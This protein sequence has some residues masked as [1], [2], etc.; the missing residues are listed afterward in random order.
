MTEVSP[1]DASLLSK[2]VELGNRNRNT[3]GLMPKGAFREFARRG[4]LLVAHID[5]EFVGYALYEV[6]RRRVRLT[7]LCVDDNSRSNGVARE[8]VDTLS[9]KHHDLAGI[10]VTCR[11]DFPADGLWP[12]LGFHARHARPGRGKDPTT[13]IHWWRDHGLPDLFTTSAN[14]EV[15]VVAIDHNVF[16]DLV[17]EPDR[18]DAEESRALEADWLVGR[19]RLAV[20]RETPNEIRKNLDAIERLR[21][22]SK[23]E[24]FTQLQYTPVERDRAKAAW[25]GAV[26]SPRRKDAEDCRHLISAAAGGVRIFVTRD[27]DLI[28]RYRTH[29]ADALGLR[30]LRPSELIVQLDEVADAA[31]YRPVDLEGTELSVGVYGNE[32][33]GELMRFLDHA[34][35]ERKNAYARR[36]RTVAVDQ[37]AHRQWVRDAAGNALAAWATYITPDAQSLEVPLFRIDRKIPVSATLARLLVLEIKRQALRAARTVVCV[38][39][40]YLPPGVRT[41]LLADGFRPAGETQELQCAV[42]DARSKDAAISLAATDYPMRE[43][44]S[45]ALNAASTVEQIASLERSLWPA[46][47]L[48]SNLETWIVPIRP[49]WAAELLGTEQTL[50]YRPDVLGLSRELVYYHAPQNNPS[51]PARIVWYASGAGKQRVGAVVAISQLIAVDTDAPERL[52]RRY[53]HLGVYALRDVEAVAHNGRAS[54]L[55]FVDTEVLP[56]FVPYERLKELA[57]PNGLTTLQ[58]PVRIGSSLFGQIY[59]EGTGRGV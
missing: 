15:A 1:N 17:I 56:R 31:K 45:A 34:A 49:T 20:T 22:W 21:H 3:L 29:A 23:L 11:R 8:L 27:E 4:F 39:D 13:L 52:H 41:A 19:I 32:A 37:M 24:L 44:V 9:R 38:T 14:D 58:G 57:G 30:I 47:L 5:A 50:L 33:H 40:P 7:H 12:V 43:H 10:L 46:K 2:V 25:D 42:L 54:A 55:R 16:I 48:D 18:P 36:L 59:Q 51:V 28:S 6:A 53:Q 35:G 26:S